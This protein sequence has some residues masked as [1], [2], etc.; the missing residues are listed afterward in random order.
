M[1]L[2][3]NDRR[4]RDADGAAIVKYREIR[5]NEWKEMVRD[6]LSTENPIEKASAIPGE[7]HACGAELDRL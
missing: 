6:Y 7:C 4:S 1:S 3:T 2:T 5:I